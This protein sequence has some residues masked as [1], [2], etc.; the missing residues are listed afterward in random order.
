[1]IRPLETITSAF[2]TAGFSLAVTDIEHREERIV[3]ETDLAHW[4]DRAK[5]PWGKFIGE[6]VGEAAFAEMKARISAQSKTGPLVWRWKSV[7]VKASVEKH[8]QRE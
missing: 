5:S 8:Q 2:F 6:K 1:V 4:F 3:G 7:L